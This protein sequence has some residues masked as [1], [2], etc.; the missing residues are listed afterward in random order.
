MTRTLPA[1]SP[2]PYRPEPPRPQGAATSEILLAALSGLHPGLL[3]LELL[4]DRIEV[5]G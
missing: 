5:R 4:I 3:P 1:L 2:T